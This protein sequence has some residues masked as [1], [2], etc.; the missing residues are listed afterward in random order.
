C[1]G[2][3]VNRRERSTPLRANFPFVNFRAR[4]VTQGASLWAASFPIFSWRRKKRWPPEGVP[5]KK[6]PLPKAKN[7]AETEKDDFRKMAPPKE[8]PPVGKS[9][10]FFP[11][12]GIKKPGFARL[13]L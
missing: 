4:G 6:K 12:E 7:L 5:S 8:F 10:P 2:V 11:R 3:S 1:T 9:M 13:F